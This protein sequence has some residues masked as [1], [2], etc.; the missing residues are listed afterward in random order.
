MNRNEAADLLAIAAA[1][2]KRKVGESDVT[3]WQLALQDFSFSEAT[4]AVVAHARDSKE[5]L[6]V[7]H[8][9]DRIR[10]ARNDFVERQSVDPEYRNDRDTARDNRLAELLGGERRILEAS[11]EGTGRPSDVARATKSLRPIPSGSTAR[12][13][14]KIGSIAQAMQLDVK[15]PEAAD[16]LIPETGWDRIRVARALGRLNSPKQADCDCTPGMCPHAVHREPRPAGRVKRAPITANGRSRA[17]RADS[18][19]AAAFAVLAS[20][21]FDVK[22]AFPNVA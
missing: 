20:R 4:G 14:T 18:S 15:A 10:K 7:F 3:A 22:Q 6:T 8:I 1:Y 9:A 2:D 19:Q 11:G 21:G 5:Y 17:D 16:R 13:A 12:D